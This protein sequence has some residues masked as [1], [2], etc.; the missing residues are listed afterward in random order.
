MRLTR[1]AVKAGFWGWVL[2]T[3]ILWA[4]L[5]LI[6]SQSGETV[7]AQPS[8]TLASSVWRTVDD[9]QL[10]PGER[11]EP[12]GVWVIG[13]VVYVAGFAEQNSAGFPLIFDGHWIV[14]K[15]SDGGQTWSTVR[16]FKLSGSSSSPF[17][18]AFAR[19]VGQTLNGDVFVVG[20]AG[21]G[22]S[23]HWFVEQSTNGG[24]TWTTSDDFQLVTTLGRSSLALD[25][26]QDTTTGYLYVSGSGGDT[27]N[28]QHGIVRRST[29]GGTSWSTVED[30]AT[31]TPTFANGIIRTQLGEL[32]YVGNAFPN[33]IA[34]R[35]ATGNLGSWLLEDTFLPGG[36]TGSASAVSIFRD[37]AFNLYAPGLAQTSSG[38]G[39]GFVRKSSDGGDNW[40]TV[41]SFQLAAGFT[42]FFTDG[43]GNPAG[44]IFVSM[45]ASDGSSNRWLVQRSSDGGGTWTTEDNYQLV[46]GAPAFARGIDSGLSGNLYA[47]GFAN[48]GTSSASNHWIV[49]KID[50]GCA[51]TVLRGVQT[52]EAAGQLSGHTCAIV[53][54][55]GSGQLSA[56]CWGQNQVGQVGNGATLPLFDGVQL[57]TDV[58]GGGGFTE[59]DL[60]G[61][62]TCAIGATNGGACWGA[63]SF[64]QLGI[65]NTVEQ[66]T[67]TNVFGLP[68][69]TEVSAG[70]FHACAVSGPGALC[71]GLDG[72]NGALGNGPSA[73][74]STVPVPVVGLEPAST[75]SVVEDISAGL[76]HT[77]AVVD[78]GAMCW[79]A[80]GEGQLGDGTTTGSQIPVSVNLLP[81][82]G[83]RQVGASNRFSC[84][85][86]DDPPVMGKIFCWGQDALGQVGNGAPF[87]VRIL[88]PVEVIDSVSGLPVQNAIQ[89]S[90]GLSH[91][92]AVFSDGAIRCWGDNT[93]LQLGDQG[94]CGQPCSS[95]VRV[96]GL[97]GLGATYVSAG[98]RSTCAVLENSIAACWG[99]RA[100]F[101]LGIGGTRFGVQA[102][103]SAVLRP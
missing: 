51:D 12:L 80:N 4:L 71:W 101:R 7:H 68:S 42:T 81:T 28:F 87:D 25:F 49:R 76:E 14:R 16:D 32:V 35:S 59:I 97:Q 60:G 78:A 90:T 11:A 46:P 102:F 70:R 75:S 17:D 15:S 62:F 3:P 55:G 54:D 63:N 95:A 103:P 13:G 93:N 48:D 34:K 100:N 27:S 65:G 8:C 77:C 39:T 72:V 50:I 83:V 10:A 86:V 40:T 73:F 85:L 26:M 5:H 58:V 56:K 20:Q 94:I 30:D 38:I 98:Q 45:G 21:D 9:F 92:C 84:A 47:V 52:V 69:F 91:A 44:D 36:F 33:W 61:D 79:G 64:G 2:L 29:N 41:R 6:L 67:P 43:T 22:A 89:I 66:H 99:L 23:V 31:V 24:S 37:A 57:P 82:V 88:T 74:T 1:N 96:T 53:A 18:T 19:K